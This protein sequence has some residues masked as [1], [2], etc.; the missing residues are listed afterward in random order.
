MCYISVD[1]C[2]AQQQKTKSIMPGNRGPQT[3]PAAPAGSSTGTKQIDRGE[4]QGRKHTLLQHAQ[5]QQVDFQAATT[6]LDTVKKNMA[7][8]GENITNDKVGDLG[9]KVK[10]VLQVAHGK[11][12]TSLH[13]VNIKFNTL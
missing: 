12:E 7:A 4:I 8:E 11:L 6:A 5:E 1:A 2:G 13:E 9:P 10:Q 3:V